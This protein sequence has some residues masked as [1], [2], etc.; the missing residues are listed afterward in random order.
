M[1]R[2][3]MG[4]NHRLHVCRHQAKIEV[5]LSTIRQRWRPSKNID[6]HHNPNNVQMPCSEFPWTEEVE[7][8][9]V[10][11]RPKAK[12]SEARYASLRTKINVRIRGG[13]QSQS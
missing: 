4:I 6:V 1:G 7:N 5:G 8:L 10:F 11:T 3:K 12:R 9:C 13:G 2:G